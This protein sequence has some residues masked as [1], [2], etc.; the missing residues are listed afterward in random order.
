MTQQADEDV[1][2]QFLQEEQRH[3]TFQLIQT[4]YEHKQVSVKALRSGSRIREVS[5]V[6]LYLSEKLINEFGLSLAETAHQLGVTT[7]AIANS[8][9]RKM[10]KV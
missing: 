3:R 8:H 5:R 7:A 10:I 4:V 1:K 2:H 6:R 9:R